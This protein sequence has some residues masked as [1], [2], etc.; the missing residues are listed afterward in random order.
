MP[1]RGVIFEF[2]AMSLAPKETCHRI[3]SLVM[4][5]IIPLWML[6]F[7]IVGVAKAQ[8]VTTPLPPSCELGG[9]RCIISCS[10]PFATEYTSVSDCQGPGRCCLP[11]PRECT[12]VGGECGITV[13]DGAREIINTT[14]AGKCFIRG[15]TPCSRV[16]GTCAAMCQ[17]GYAEVPN[18]SCPTGSEKCCRLLACSA[19][20]FTVTNTTC[21]QWSSQGK[22]CCPGFYCKNDLI[23]T[24]TNTNLGSKMESGIRCVKEADGLADSVAKSAEPVIFK[25]QVS[26]PG[27]I[28][29][30]G[31][32]IEFKKCLPGAT[33][34]GIEITGDTLGQY[35]K[36]F[37]Q[38]FTAAIAVMAVVMVMWGGFK[39]IMAAGS[40]E[41]ISAA[42]ETIGGALT[43]LVLALL[44]Y[45]LLAL[46]NPALLTLK[47]LEI[48]TVK[49]ETFEYLPESTFVAI[50]GRKPLPPLGDKMLAI[51]RQLATSENV[52][53]CVLK[54]IVAAESGGREDQVGHDEHARKTGVASRD[55]FVMDYQC[56]QFNSKQPAKDCEIEGQAQN[57]DK[58][59]QSKPDLGLDWRYSHGFGIAQVTIFPTKISEGGKIGDDKKQRGGKGKVC[60]G[61]PCINIGGKDY[62]PR[63]LMKTETSVEAMARLWKEK[64]RGEVSQQC[65]KSYNGAG[66]AAEDYGARAMPYYENCLVA[67]GR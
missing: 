36:V 48:Y 42:N 63:D 19:E 12:Q 67:G 54:T 59:D 17:E 28:S 41:K 61:V 51:V 22:R 23:N 2:K 38:F 47:T 56:E 55:R 14:C 15:L 6:L 24:V 29:I 37:F 35:I 53:F 30:G 45:S 66:Q 34:C 39:R 13:P 7:V 49:K 9:G 64:C 18:S 65:F 4:V 33:S 46:I 58:V 40:S 11:V 31:K 32:A 21:G 10:A 3:I 50:T 44:S 1:G 8:I 27:S 43:G 5:A 25:P 52:P 57:D 60:G 16:A 26:I 20:G 62:L